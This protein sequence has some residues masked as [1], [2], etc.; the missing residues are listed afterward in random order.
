MFYILIDLQGSQTPLSS[1]FVISV[2]Y[3][4]IDLQGSQTF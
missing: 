2:F 1:H 3:I 4:L